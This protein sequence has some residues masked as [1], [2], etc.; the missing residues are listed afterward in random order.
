[1][2]SKIFSEDPNGVEEVTESGNVII[3]ANGHLWA[4]K[5]ARDE[6]KT[7]IRVDNVQ[8]VVSLNDFI[9]NS[10]YTL[11]YKEWKLKFS[12]ASDAI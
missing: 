7:I 11:L 9:S 10:I 2:L 1:M 5:S 8:T 6:N 3:T 12:S 4:S